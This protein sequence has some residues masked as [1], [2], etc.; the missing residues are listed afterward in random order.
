MAQDF[1]TTIGLSANASSTGQPV[2]FDGV[3][4]TGLTVYNNS[5]IPIQY[6]LDGSTWTTVANAATAAPAVTNPSAFRLRKSTSDSYPVPVRLVWSA[7]DNSYNPASVAITGGSIGGNNVLRMNNATRQLKIIPF[8]DSI[9][10]ASTGFSSGIWQ[11]GNGYAETSIY[12]AGPRFQLLRNAGI[13]GNT[14]AQMLARL[15]TDVLAYSPDVVLMLG[16][17]N[18]ILSGMTNAAIA[19]TMGNLENMVRQMLKAGVLPIIVTPPTKDGAPTETRKIQWF[20]YAL[21]QAY[22]LPLLDLYRLTVNPATGNFIAGYSGDGTHPLPAAVDAIALVASQLLANLQSAVC[23]PYMAAYSETSTNN[24]ANLI[25][26][27]SFAQSTVPPT[28]DGWTVNTT[29]ATQTIPGVTPTYAA[30]WT[31]NAFT[32]NKTVS[33]GAYAASGGGITAFSA[34]DVIQFS[35]HIIASGLT[36]ASASGFTLALD[37]I[38]SGNARPFTSCPFNADTVFCMQ[39]TIPA[40]TTSFS[41][42]LYVQDVGLYKMNNITAV[43]VTQANAIWTPSP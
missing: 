27:G 23:Q 43:N 29:N 24:F 19:T 16:G 36:P 28:P 15:S 34:G 2:D 11:F 5:G 40:G 17:T 6:S 37:L 38:P 9:T 1:D 41:P 13:A 12:R 30:P 31:G 7:A 35:G 3:A 22:G 21:A 4:V 14:T 8:G 20:Y 39:A 42:S 26:N 32:Y 10:A 18:D 33:G 25:R